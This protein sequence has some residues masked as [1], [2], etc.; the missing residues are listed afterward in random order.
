[1]KLNF[2]TFCSGSGNMENTIP[3]HWRF[4]LPPII[5]KPRLKPIT[6]GELQWVEADNQL[7]DGS[8]IGGYEN[9]ILYIIR[10]RHSG[11]LTPGKFVPS[12]GVGYIAW[13]GLSHEKMAFEVLCGFDCTWIPTCDNKIPVGAVEGGYSEDRKR[14][15]LYVGRALYNGHL[16]PGKVQPSHQVCYIPYDGREI[17]VEKY[18]ILTSFFENQRCANKLLDIQLYVDLNAPNSES[19]AEDAEVENAEFELF[20]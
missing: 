15:K 6:G 16:V 17:A 19:E 2:I 7:P 12:E 4:E 13:G 18:E 20:D 14:E 11:S 3:V 8:M 1:M 5:E 10:A 9:E